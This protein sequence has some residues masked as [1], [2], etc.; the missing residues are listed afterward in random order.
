LNLL[1]RPKIYEEK[2]SEFDELKKARDDA[3]KKLTNLEKSYAP[4]E[5]K[6]KEIERCWAKENENLKKKVFMISA[7]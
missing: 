4:L 1:L 6:K 5:N 3:Q 2:K 7:E